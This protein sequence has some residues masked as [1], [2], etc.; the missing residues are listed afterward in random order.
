MLSYEGESSKNLKMIKSHTFNQFLCS[1]GTSHKPYNLACCTC[2]TK[3]YT[4]FIVYNS[5]SDT[6]AMKG[7]LICIFDK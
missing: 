5:E 7:S 3:D 4:Q 1:V 2:I 6:P